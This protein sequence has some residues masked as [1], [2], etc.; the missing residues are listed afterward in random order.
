MSRGRRALVLGV[1]AV[2]LGGLA[3]SDVAEREAALERRLGPQVSV[4]VA[5]ATIERG[6]PIT[7]AKLAVRRVPARF[8]PRAAFADAAEVTGAR[9]AGDIAAGSDLAPALLAEA[10]SDSEAALVAAGPGERIARIVAVGTPEELFPG[11][12][13]DVLITTERG[14]GR[15]RTRVALRGAQV[16]EVAPV[17]Q[18]G[19]SEGDG[20]PR[21]AL[22][23]RVS[24]S[25]A[26]QLTEAQAGA[27]ELRVLPRPPS[28]SR[29]VP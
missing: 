27:R 15:A 18:G 23:L 12:R 25:D 24:L 3:A 7:A 5:R 11:T 1:L 14:V 28:A 22:A 4:V 17:A 26:V 20:L 10:G 2:L 8:A 6:A 16:V 19:A 13:A 21:V 29:R 9:A